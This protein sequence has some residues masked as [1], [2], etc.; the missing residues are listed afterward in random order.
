[1]SPN[2]SILRTETPK[3]ALVQTLEKKESAIKSTLEVQEYNR[4]MTA[5]DFNYN[6]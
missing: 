4:L 1:M 6:Q 3:I 5:D 2:P